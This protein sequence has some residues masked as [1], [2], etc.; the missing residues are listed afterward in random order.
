VSAPVTVESYYR[1][2]WGSF[3]DFLAIYRAHHAPVL[4][5][6]QWRGFIFAIRTETPV[7]HMAGDQ[8]LRVI[9][10]L[11]GNAAL[12]VDGGAYERAVRAADGRWTVGA[13]ALAAGFVAN[14]GVRL[15]FGGN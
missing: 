13:W 12:G 2:R 11:D 15:N 6:L 14:A 4:A 8:D 5:E 7:S 9:T 1:I 10:Y 3:W